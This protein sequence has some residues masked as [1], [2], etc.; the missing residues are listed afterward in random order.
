MLASGG[1]EADSEAEYV[2]ERL[3]DIVARFEA[4]VDVLRLDVG[5]ETSAESAVVQAVMGLDG[6]SQTIAFGTEA[7][8]LARMGAEAVVV[9]P[10][11]MLTA[12]SPRE[13]VPLVELD[14]CVQ[15]L[16]AAIE[17]LCG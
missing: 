13:G 10:G 5:F 11:S 3:R 15:V 14:R 12:H 2:L 16:Q 6:L 1:V 4:D 17:R 7:P 8:W 9:G